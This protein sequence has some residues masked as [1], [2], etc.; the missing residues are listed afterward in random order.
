MSF[1]LRDRQKFCCDLPWLEGL[2]CI[3]NGG[4]DTTVPV[5]YMGVGLDHLITSIPLMLLTMQAPSSVSSNNELKSRIV[6]QNLALTGSLITPR[7]AFSTRI[8]HA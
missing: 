6:L 4:L 5:E 2:K 8:L 1:A 7:D 3:R